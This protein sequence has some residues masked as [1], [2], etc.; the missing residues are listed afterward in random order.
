[1]EERG[2]RVCRQCGYPRRVPEQIAARGIPTCKACQIER[3]KVRGRVAWIRKSGGVREGTRLCLIC[4]YV[5]AIGRQIGPRA[6]YCQKCRRERDA[7]RRR[8]AH[9]T[10]TPEQRDLKR[11]VDRAQKALARL[12]RPDARERE[13]AASRRWRQRHPDRM[14]EASRRWMAKIKQDPARLAAHRETRRMENRLRRERNGRQA[15]IPSEAS[16]RNGHGAQR[17]AVA[18]LPAAPLIAVL[19]E[20]LGPLEDRSNGE[21]S[22]AGEEVLAEL[23]GIADRNIRRILSGEQLTVR[24]QTADRICAALDLPLHTIYPDA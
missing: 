3:N 1:M 7:A 8:Y 9:H 16:Y 20:W 14:L 12:S 5:R 19:Q 15:Q 22:T 17:L 18:R 21:R 23:I 2:L 10:M 13:N 11:E 6:T 24:Y 4:G